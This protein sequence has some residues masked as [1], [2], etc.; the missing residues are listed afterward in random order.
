MIFIISGV[1]FVGILMLILGAMDMLDL[2]AY[3]DPTR[4]K[5]RIAG[6]GQGPAQQHSIDIVRKDAIDGGSVLDRALARFGPISIIKK[7][8]LQANST[9]PMGVFVLLSILLSLIGAGA[10][11]ASQLPVLQIA[12][13]TIGGLLL[14]FLYQVRARNK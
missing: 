2:V 3:G 8:L 7:V 9:M 13:A 6:V 5:K 14:P 1:A 11:Y 4:T 12:G 10:A